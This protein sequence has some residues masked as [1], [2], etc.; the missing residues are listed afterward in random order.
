MA[1]TGS[2]AQRQLVSDT[3]ALL[4]IRLSAEEL[5]G[6]A[7]SLPVDPSAVYNVHLTEAALWVVDAA[8]ASRLYPLAVAADA[9]GVA[10]SRVVVPVPD[11]ARRFLRATS[12][13]WLADAVL[14]SDPGSPMHVLAQASIFAAHPSRPVVVRLV[15]G[16]E[17]AWHCYPARGPVTVSYVPDVPPEALDGALRA[18][19]VREGAA[20]LAVVLREG[21]AGALHAEAAQ[22][23]ETP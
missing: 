16:A 6:D 19:C 5:V 9:V 14:L 18:A 2:T 12:S 23:L 11:G 1:Y 22:L 15:E 13:G 4:D 7:L 21:D 17:D 8:P 10:G 3:L 20:R